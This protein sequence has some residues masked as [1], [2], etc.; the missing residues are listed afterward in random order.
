[1][2]KLPLTVILPVH[3]EEKN[4]R[5]CLESVSFADDLIVV[6]GASSDRTREIAS[7]FPARILETENDFAEGQRLKALPL[8][9]H[10]WI[11]LID[12]DE[13]V[14]EPLRDSIEKALNEQKN[15]AYTVRRRNLYKGR[16]IHMHEPDLQLRLFQKNRTVFPDK[17]HRL[18]QIQ[19]SAGSLEGDLLHYFFTTVGDYMTR[20]KRYTEAEASYR[21]EQANQAGILF[22]LNGFVIRPSGRFFHYYFLKKGF[23][24]GSFG[25]FYSISSAYYEWVIASKLLNGLK[26]GSGGS[27]IH[28]P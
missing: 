20:L 26:R 8:A 15:S 10:P 16:P 23:L 11:F 27:E 25:F 17:I 13:V 19:G 4:I 2:A 6:D 7:H 18:P 28:R 22:W 1:M 5:R 14:T 3:N 12:A 21:R 24:D 9:R